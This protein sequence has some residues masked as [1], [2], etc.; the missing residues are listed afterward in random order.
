MMLEGAL[1]SFDESMRVVVVGL[2]GAEDEGEQPAINNDQATTA[3]ISLNV[4][5]GHRITADK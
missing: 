4:T 3:C 1:V 5:R 2:E